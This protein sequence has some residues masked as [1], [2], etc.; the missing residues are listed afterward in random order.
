MFHNN[1]ANTAV[2]EIMVN[3]DMGMGTWTW[4]YM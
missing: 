2:L 4:T 3:M 1:P